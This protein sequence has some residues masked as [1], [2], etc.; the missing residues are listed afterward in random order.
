VALL[1]AAVA[2]VLAAVSS[3]PDLGDP[4]TGLYFT[5]LSVALWA[6]SARVR[7][8]RSAA[9]F[10]PRLRIAFTTAMGLGALLAAADL[11][12]AGAL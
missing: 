9:P 4:I 3:G 6:Q 11:V 8:S 12:T 10:T 5:A 2:A 7:H 1:V